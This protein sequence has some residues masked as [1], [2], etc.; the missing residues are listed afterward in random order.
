M[1]LSSK[2]IALLLI[3]T[4]NKSCVAFTCRSLKAKHLNGPIAFYQPNP[5][6][7]QGAGS[8]AMSASAAMPDD[9]DEKN[10]GSDHGQSS[11]EFSPRRPI[12]PDGWKTPDDAYDNIKN[13]V[14]SSKPGDSTDKSKFL[15]GDD[16]V[17]LRKRLDKLRFDLNEAR[18]LGDDTTI[19]E[20]QIELEKE[21]NMDP[22]LVY[23]AY[24][25]KASMAEDSDMTEKLKKYRSQALEARS[26]LPQY[27]LEGLWVGKYGQHGY[28][29]INIT[30]VGDI[31]MATKITGDKNVPKGQVTFTAD[32]NPSSSSEDEA[33][34]PIKLTDEAAKQWG[35]RHLP[36]FSGRGQV[37]T[38]GFINN[39]WLDGQLILVGEYFSFAWLPLGYQIFFGR[40]SASLTLKLLKETQMTEFGATDAKSPDIYAE[41]RL[42]A[43]R[44]Y[45]ESENIEDDIETEGGMLFT[46]DD[47]SYYNQDGCFE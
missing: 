40:P 15:F 19:S 34:E 43:Q 37:A 28:E 47:D 16:L 7:V 27:N 8:L 18:E 36:R 6:Y 32:L 21:V 45:E 46:N 22:Q 20:L 30:Y 13:A 29:M 4:I 25:Q 1:S 14:P 31:L 42:F 12:S 11:Q 5:T 38:E 23:E 33:I 17:A 10:S 41:M 9:W 24:M 44:C 3:T 35:T 39:Q 2:L 26:F